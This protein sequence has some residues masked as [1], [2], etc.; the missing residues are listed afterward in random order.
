MTQDL[1]KSGDEKALVATK[2]AKGEELAKAAKAAGK[3]SCWFA[4][5][6]RSE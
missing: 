1:E 6:L 4:D 5:A 3:T 2:K